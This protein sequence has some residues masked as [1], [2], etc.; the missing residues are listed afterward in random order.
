MGDNDS[1]DDDDDDDELSNVLWASCVTFFSLYDTL[2]T[3]NSQS[4]VRKLTQKD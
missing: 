4:K 3:I 2:T 1:V